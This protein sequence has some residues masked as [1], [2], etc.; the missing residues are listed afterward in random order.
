[1]NVTEYNQL[2]SNYGTRSDYDIVRD[3]KYFVYNIYTHSIVAGNE[4]KEDAQ[5][6]CD[7]CNEISY[8]PVTYKVYTAKHIMTRLNLNPYDFKNWSNP[9]K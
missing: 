6:V 1:M 8:K 2:K 4:Y 3:Y 5:D 7:E 9:T